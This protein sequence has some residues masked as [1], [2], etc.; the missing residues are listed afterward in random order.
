MLVKFRIPL[1]TMDINQSVTCVDQS[2]SES[3]CRL[4]IFD[5]IKAM[6]DVPTT[7]E[8]L[9]WRLSVA[10]RKD[11]PHRLLTSYDIDDAFKAVRTEQGSG[12]RKKRVVLEIINTVCVVIFA[13]DLYELICRCLH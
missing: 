9:A 7:Y 1:H 13:S 3:D 5:R 2:Y 11:P 10:R 8:H 6:M 4:D 12:R